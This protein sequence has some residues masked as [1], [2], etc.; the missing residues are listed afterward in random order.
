MSK[1]AERPCKFVVSYCG[2]H[3][4]TAKPVSERITRKISSQKAH[5][6]V[7]LSAGGALQNIDGMRFYEKSGFC[8]MMKTIECQL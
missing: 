1:A 8:E 3:F 2:V 5:R 7:V 6:E 4:S